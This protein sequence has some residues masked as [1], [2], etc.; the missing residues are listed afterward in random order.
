M[1][2]CFMLSAFE[3]GKN[4][5]TIFHTAKS[6]AAAKDLQ[7]YLEKVFGK[8]YQLQYYRSGKHQPGIFVGIP[9][10]DA[11]LAL[12]GEK[13]YCVLTATPDKLY[14][15]GNDARKL[16]G[17]D[18]AV[19]DFL[20]KY[21]AVRFLWPGELGTVAEP[22]KPV[23]IRNGT[24]VFVPCFDL[25]LTSSFTYGTGNLTKSERADLYKWMTRRKVGRAIPSKGSGFQHAFAKLVPRD[26]YGKTHPEYYSLITPDRWIGEPKPSVPTRTNDPTVGGPWQLCTSNPEV[27]RIIAEKI[28][29]KSGIIQSISPNDGYGFCQCQKCTAQDGKDVER[30]GKAGH[31]RVTNRMYDFAEDIAKQVYK[32]NPDAK[33]GMFAYSFYDGVPDQKIN[34]PGNTYLS[35]CYIVY[36]MNKA[37]EAE[38]TDKLIGLAATGGKVIGREYWG[39]HYTMNYPLSHSRKI[40]RNV[41]L[42]KKLN[43]AGIYGETG[44]DFAARASDLYILTKLAWDPDL[45]RED[46]LNDFCTAAFGKKAAPIM[47]EL[48]EKIEDRVEAK[49]ETHLD[50]YGK[51]FN[52]YPNDYAEFNRFLTTIFDADF[53]KMC[54]PYLKKAYKTADSAERKARVEFIQRGIGYAAITTEYL[55]S[56]RNLAAAGV[57]MALTQPSENEIVMEKANL[58]KVAQR[59]VKASQ[60]RERYLDNSAQDSALRRGTFNTISL[61]PWKAMAEISLVRLK[62]G[63]FNYIVNGA[64]EYRGYSWQSEIVK[65]SGKCSYTTE[66]N[67]DAEDNYMVP[68]HAMQGVSCQL[69]VDP[70][71][72]MNLIQKRA[73]T[74]TVPMRATFSMFVKCTGNPLEQISVTLGDKKFVGEWV[75]RA[76]AA[77]NN[78]WCELRFHPVALNA[79]NHILKITAT[80]TGKNAAKFNFDELQLR[81]KEIRTATR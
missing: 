46:I 32:L 3:L 13:E 19:A 29:S 8:K 26:K 58:I 9:Q 53:Q 6:R 59:A 16:T 61:R 30:R 15:Y 45:K 79:G 37:Q 68:C 33:M 75:N 10:P 18:Y 56:C 77:E 51:Y 21:C 65:G 28:A 11:K 43:A 62:S 50:N 69:D 5:S 54:A 74:T 2:G 36:R 72:T 67:C 22:Q 12:P 31:L 48:F 20:E 52:D 1:S 27:R 34:F 63:S 17:T 42:L 35:F 80:N 55:D 57:N 70:V 14:I 81:L 23:E 78:N 47:Y 40:D 73:V 38:L 49:I 66:T 4:D 39:T 7:F 64:F 24:D 44:R 60:A 71:S 41:K 25:R 76:F